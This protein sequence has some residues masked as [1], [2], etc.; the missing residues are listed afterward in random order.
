MADATGI[1]IDLAATV[2]NRDGAAVG[3]LNEIVVERESRQ[4]AGF[5]ILTDE[6]APREV[7]VMVGQ[8]ERVEHDRLTLDLSDAELVALPDARQHLFVAPQQDLDEE[9]AAAE[10][11]TASAMNPDPDE[12]AAFSG[13]PGVALTPNLMIPM[14]IERAIMDDDQVAFQA[15]MRVLTATGEE[16]GQIAGIIVDDE[17]RLVALDLQGNDDRRI[18]YDAIDTLDVDANELTLRAEGTPDVDARS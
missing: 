4:V 11:D 7:F 14:E 12:R 17:A 15:G 13:I 9:I 8:V 6:L 3:R 2:T 1:R 5:H 10:S 18:A 16:I